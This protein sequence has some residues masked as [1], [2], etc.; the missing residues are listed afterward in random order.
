MAH[1]KTFKETSMFGSKAS[2]VLLLH[3]LVCLLLS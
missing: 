3:K 2:L 1:L